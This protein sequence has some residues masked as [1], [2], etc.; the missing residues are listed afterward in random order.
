M[1]SHGQTVQ[2]AGGAGWRVTRVSSIPGLGGG[3]GNR[4]KGGNGQMTRRQLGRGREMVRLCWVRRGT[5]R[6]AR[7]MTK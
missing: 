7:K 5:E 2:R 3:S 4:R 1:A 6:E